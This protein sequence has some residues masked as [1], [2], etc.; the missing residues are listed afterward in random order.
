V[1]SVAS[2]TDYSGGYP[3]RFNISGFLHGAGNG[4][5]TSNC[6]SVGCPGYGSGYFWTGGLSVGVWDFHDNEAVANAIG[7]RVWQNNGETHRIVNSTLWANGTGIDHGAYGNN[8]EFD[9][10]TV[11]GNGYPIHVQAVSEGSQKWSNMLVDGGGGTCQN[12]AN[13]R[14]VTPLAPTVLDHMTYQNYGAG[15]ALSIY[16][17]DGNDPA[18]KIQVTACTFTGGAN[19]TGNEAGVS[20]TYFI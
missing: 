2:A 12:F 4:N 14:P 5:K 20:G 13:G 7:I 16:A 1:D 17:A 15:P 3:N 11:I 8:Y 19:H 10:G 18:Q 6:L 9:G